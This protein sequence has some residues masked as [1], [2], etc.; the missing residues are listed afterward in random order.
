MTTPESTIGVRHYDVGVVKTAAR[1]RWPEILATLG[2][3]PRESLDGKH[4]PCPK[5]GGVDRFRMIDQDAGALFCNQCFNSRNG[6]GLAALAWA[7]GQD[8]ETVLRQLAEHL[9]L[10]P[11]RNG[12][13]KGRR[14]SPRSESSGAVY[15]NIDAAVR[16]AILPALRR[17]FP[18]SPP[19]RL[20]RV[21]KYDGFAVARVDLPTPTGEKQQK[22]FR[23]IYEFKLS[24]GRVAWKLGYWT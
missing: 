21:D 12:R 15:L 7:T 23:P 16:A 5:C 20:V 18:G 19:P 17:K 10:E 1:G 9:G 22:T 4:G 3:I 13:P 2:R 8:F 24:D 6:D 14:Q 11:S